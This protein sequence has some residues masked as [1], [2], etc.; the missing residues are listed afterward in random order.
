MAAYG[1]C[2]R[3]ESRIVDLRFHGRYGYAEE[4]AKLGAKYQIDGNIL[5]LH[6]NGGKLQGA[7]VKALD[8]RAG[9]ALALLGLVADGQTTIEEAWMIERGY[10]EFEKKLLSLG[11]NV[12]L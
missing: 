1:A 8:L 5:K 10:N 3:G 12:I 11:A 9:A 2:A 4:F 7:T 6:G